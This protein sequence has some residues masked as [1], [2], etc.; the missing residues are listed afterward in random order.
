MSTKIQWTDETWNPITG[1]TKISPGCRNCYAERMAKR[2]AGRC[3]YPADDPFAVT[4]HLDR[5]RQPSRWRKPRRVFVCS[6]GDL[7]H[8]DVPLLDIWRVFDVMEAA[9]RHTFQ[10]LTKRPQRM[11]QAS[12]P[13]PLPN[14]WLGVSVE[15]R[16]QLDRIDALGDTPAHVRF[17][18]FEPLLGPIHNV[19]LTGIDWIIIGGESG[20]GARRCSVV[21]FRDLV[22][23]ARAARVPVFVKQ[24]GSYGWRHPAGADP[25]EWPE[26]L[27]VREWPEVT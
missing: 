24:L 19:D 21:W 18:S 8:E 12:P 3:G 13:Q 27:R 10:V 6:M 14:V 16:D 15:S 7:F 4:I 5:L 22:R 23:R 20:P 2:L 26:D 25:S 11:A 9:D 1:C 17:V